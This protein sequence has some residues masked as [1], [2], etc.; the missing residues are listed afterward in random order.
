MPCRGSGRT[1]AGGGCEAAT[2][3]HAVHGA[4]EPRNERRQ[5]GAHQR[6]L[7]LSSRKLIR[8]F[9]VSPYVTPQVDVQNV[10]CRGP[11]AAP[12]PSACRAVSYTHLRAHETPEQVV[13]RLLLEK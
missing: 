7:R 13:C 5:E 10:V 9:I 12:G 2:H 6:S 11:L 1:R 3:R 4:R 8:S